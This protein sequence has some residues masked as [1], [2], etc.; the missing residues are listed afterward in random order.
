MMLKSGCA[1][2]LVLMSGLAP[3]AAQD[4][5]SLRVGDVYP[6][7]HYIADALVKPW[8]ADVKQ[9][10]GDR[11]DI[12][13]FPAEQLGKGPQ[14]LSLTQQGVVDVGIIVPPFLPDKLPRSA[15][16]ELPGGFSTACEGTKA[17]WQLATSG[18]L[19]EKEYTPN[20]VRVLLATVLPPYQIFLRNRI[21]GVKSFSGQKIYSTGGA[22]D[23]TVRKFGGVPTRMV[24]SEVHEAMSRGT[25]DGG[26]MAY[27][28]ALAYRLPGLVK[29]ATAGEN[30]G[31]GVITY[32]ISL[33]K[34]N[35]LP[36]DLRKVLD[37]TGEA[38]T[39]RACETITKGV[40]AEIVR[41]KQGGVTLVELPASDR[42]FVDRE[43]AQV[44]R[45]WAK[46]LDARNLDGSAVLS[47]FTSALK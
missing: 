12:Q 40:E 39:M 45:E 2:A 41:L 25:I 34:W 42:E 4:K 47:A 9:A 11:I 1:A 21:E 32:G 27:G 33:A 35:A 18:I 23:L 28:T 44:A 37:Q 30:F 10:L 31:S 14:M 46:E 8:M 43:L 26:L 24:T 22:K 19:A 29:Y 5:T 20:N 7:G 38:A 16:A 6:A 17:F 13:Y 36:E 15:V 3:A